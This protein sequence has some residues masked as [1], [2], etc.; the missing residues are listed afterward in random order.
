MRVPRVPFAP[1]DALFHATT[2]DPKTTTIAEGLGVY[3]KTVQRWRLV[4]V[5]LF[6]ADALAVRLGF[7][8]CD[9]ELWGSEWEDAI[10][11]YVEVAEPPRLF[12]VA[13]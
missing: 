10:D 2:A 7:L 13:S 9:P 8:A 5:D 3:P 6:T 4:G 12:E 11:R 1:I